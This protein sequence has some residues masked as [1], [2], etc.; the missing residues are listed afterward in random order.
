MRWTPTS[1]VPAGHSRIAQRF[2]VGKTGNQHASPIG[3]NDGAAAALR[4]FGRPYGTSVRPRNLPRSELLGHSRASLRDAGGGT[5]EHGCDGRGSAAALAT[6]A[7]PFA[8][9]LRDVPP[10][11]TRLCAGMS[12]GVGELE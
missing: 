1:A 3:T 11:G 7:T 10:S 8:S 5:P 12:C 9:V 4:R 6:S 2:I